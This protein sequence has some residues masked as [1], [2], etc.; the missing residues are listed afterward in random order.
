MKLMKQTR[1]NVLAFAVVLGISAG[2][3]AIA[4]EYD[5]YAGQFKGSSLLISGTS[6]VHD[7][8]VT[9]GLIP[10]TLK[11][12][13][14]YSLD[15][16]VAVI[17][18]LEE[19]PVAEINLMVRSIKSGKKRMDEVMHKAMKMADFPRSSYKLK[20]LKP[21][22]KDRKAGE[23]L[24]FVSKGVLTVSGKEKELEFPVVFKPLED[25]SYEALAETKVKMT[26]FGIKPPRPK[27]AL[28]LINTGDEVTIKIVWR[29]AKK[30]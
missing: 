30:K 3:G 27:I 10:G 5:E 4:A 24:R 20:S 23:P 12:P 2:S 19:D 6:S 17:P 7:W 26:E 14:G 9:T 13:K 8:K 18:E 22:N 1:N 16:A 25:G 28:G 11:L 15:P 29:I 21:D